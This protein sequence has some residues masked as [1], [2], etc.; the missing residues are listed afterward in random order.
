MPVN[1]GTDAELAAA[2]ITP[3]KALIQHNGETIVAPM[4]DIDPERVELAC[5]DDGCVL[6]PDD[7]N[8]YN[9]VTPPAPVT[10]SNNQLSI[11][12]QQ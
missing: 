4:E 9:D 6:I 8:P 3:T 10:L 12:D 1:P 2:A 11:P 7:N 5:N